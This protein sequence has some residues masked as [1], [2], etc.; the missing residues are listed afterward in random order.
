[1][2]GRVR[3]T[4]L[5]ALAHLAVLRPAL[6]L[7]F[8]M[9]A[10]GK[11]NLE[12]LDQFI[13]VANH[14]SHL[15][16]A[17]LFHILPRRHLS[18]THPVAALDY[19]GKTKA[20]FRLAQFLFQPIWI[21]RGDRETDPLEGMRERLRQGHSIIIF[22][23]GTRGE[24][25][26]VVPFRTGVGRLAEEFREVPIVP[27]F[28]AGAER[29]LPKSSALPLPVWTRAIV[30]LPQHPQGTSRDTTEA[31]REMVAELAI[32]D[33]PKHHQRSKRPT[34]I[35]TVAVLGIDGSG[36]STLSHRLA[37]V[38]SRR[39]RVGLV[40]DNVLIFEKGVPKVIQPLVA[41]RIREAIGRRAKTAK[42][43]RSYKVPKLAE[44]LL[45]DHVVG[46]VKRWYGPDLVITDGSPLLNMT[47]WARLYRDEEPEDALLSSALG[48]L[49]G[50]GKKKED[51]EAAYQAFPE[52][53]S[54]KRLHLAHLH[55]PDA[56]LFLDVAP[57][58]SVERIQSRGEAQ[59]VHETLEKLERLRNGYRA[60]CRIME[61]DWRVPARILDG[62]QTLEAV[63]DE[64]HAALGDMAILPEKLMVETSTE[65]DAEETD[66]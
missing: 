44:L 41:E 60:V 12:G 56:V 37:E 4:F 55:C 66:D 29:A 61:P 65:A 17:F 3:F 22:P 58:T 11:R 59:Q 25:G 45:R 63:T 15:D 27:V 36:K 10:V 19:F 42:S 53:R 51:E 16:T 47:A 20:L 6:K 64:A 18:R 46:Q 5:R 1:M 38:L 40:S 34:Q 23:E 2:E 32:L 50:R 52:L 13:L 21:V 48:I 35:P 28:L 8:G 14:N 62:Q 43:L 30:G 26:I 31:L 54:M 24:P 57:A 49:S 39:G 33:R 9:S 7:I